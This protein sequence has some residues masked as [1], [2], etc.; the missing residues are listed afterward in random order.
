M[1]ILTFLHSFEPGGVE[2][3]ALRLV[4][5]WRELGVDAPLFMGRGD[6]AMAADVGQGLGFISP[7]QPVFSTAA[8]ETL[9]M[10]LTLPHVI[11]RERPDVLF[12]AGNSYT[13]VAVALK[14]LLG[15]RCPPIIA[16]ISNDLNRQDMILPVRGLYHLWLR[17]QGRVIDH[18]VAMAEGM[19]TEIVEIMRVSPDR[20]SVIHDP[21]LS[22][23]ML[24][25]L[26]NDMPVAPRSAGRRFVTIARL[27][28]QKNLGL[29]LRAFARSRGKRD[30]LTI[31]GEGPE[32]ARLRALAGQLG[33]AGHVHFLGHL[34]DPALRLRH[35]D[36]FLLSSDYEGV[37][38][39]ILE[40]LAANMP[41]I[42]TDCSRAMRALLGDG[43]LGA[44]VAPGD[45]AALAR[46][47]SFATP[48]S[49]NADASLALAQEFTIENAAD[50]YLT[51]FRACH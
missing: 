50:H 11:R 27:A 8:W 30:S 36:I 9:W 47:I 37:P 51:L 39:V 4:R 44:I 2:R 24:D 34:A 26:R 6:G 3:I 49:Q 33:I 13:V 18:I 23:A 22:T 25:A 42:A 21:A 7:R 43:A 41:I 14:L 28:P 40:A 20:V 35:Y 17:F 45:V 15:K 31:I 38:A 16:K 5:R 48:A 29:M 1:K 32:L 46:A 10:I 19:V 12:C